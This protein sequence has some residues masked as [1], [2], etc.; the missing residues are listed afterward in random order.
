MSKNRVSNDIDHIPIDPKDSKPSNEL[1]PTPELIPDFQ[2]LK[3]D[4]SLTYE[5]DNLLEGICPDDSYAI[6][7]LFFNVAT[8]Q[9][10]VDNINKYAEIYSSSNI[11]YACP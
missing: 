6:F 4:N 3:I 2:P 1:P 8:L 11:P 9:I 5:Q 10:L 7:N